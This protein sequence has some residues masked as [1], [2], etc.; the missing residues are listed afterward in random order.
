[1]Y[2]LSQRYCH[3]YSG[4]MTSLHDFGADIFDRMTLATWKVI[5]TVDSIMRP[6]FSHF[7][8][9]EPWVLLLNGTV[10]SVK[11]IKHSNTSRP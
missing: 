2:T 4:F 8:W 3:N 11:L 9:Y 5:C 10:E 1:M 6:K 7:I